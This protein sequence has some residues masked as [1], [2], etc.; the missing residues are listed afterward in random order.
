MFTWKI[1]FFSESVYN[2]YHAAM[3]IVHKADVASQA[4]TSVFYKLP[5]L[6]EHHLSDA[7]AFTNVYTEITL[8]QCPILATE[9][10]H[11]FAMK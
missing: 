3:H 7:K 4:N 1:E 2:W 8:Y 5:P 9:R 10:G 6:L 11:G